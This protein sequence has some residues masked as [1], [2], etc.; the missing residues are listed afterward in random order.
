[1]QTASVES[2]QIFNISEVNFYRFSSHRAFVYRLYTI[3]TIGVGAMLF[4]WCPWLSRV[5]FYRTYMDNADWVRVTNTNRNRTEFCRLYKGTFALSPL[6]PEHPH[7]YFLYG[8]I[9]FYFS[10]KSKCFRSLGGV[11]LRDLQKSVEQ[12]EKGVGGISKPTAKRLLRH[13]RPN[14]IDCPV[15]S[16]PRLVFREVTTPFCV[17]QCFSLIV[18]ALDNYG[19]FALLILLMMSAS[20]AF[21]VHE[22]RTQQ[23]K[24]R[25][26]TFANFAVT[27]FRKRYT[28][29][30][31]PGVLPAETEVEMEQLY[32]YAESKSDR[33]AD[34]DRTPEYPPSQNMSDLNF[35]SVGLDFH[36]KKVI[37]SVDLMVGDL[38]LVSGGHI[39]PADILIVQGKCLV[40]ESILTG[41]TI[42]VA[43]VRVQPGHPVTSNNVLYSGTSCLTAKQCMGVVVKVGMYTKKGE[44]VRNL[45]FAETTHFQF[46]RDAYIFLAGIFILTTAVFVWFIFEIALGIYAQYYHGEVLIIKGLEMFTTAIP[47]ALPLCLSIGLG[48]ASQRLTKR[49]V[50]NKILEKINEAGRIRLMCFDKTGT[51]TESSLN[52]VALMPVEQFSSPAA[53]G[54]FDANSSELKI[55]TPFKDLRS[56]EKSG[57]ITARRKEMLYQVA[58]CCHSLCLLNDEVVGDQMELQFFQQT[59]LWLV[60]GDNVDYIVDRSPLE[61]LP[62]GKTHRSVTSVPPNAQGSRTI[63]KITRRFDFTSERRRMSVVA[64]DEQNGGVSVLVKGAPEVIAKLCNQTT[65]PGNFWEVLAEYTNQGLRILAAAYRRLTFEEERGTR[66]EDFETDLTFLAFLV[67]ENP[68]KRETMGVIRMLEACRVK[69]VMITGDNLMTAVSVGIKA[70]ILDPTHHIFMAQVEG[71]RLVWTRVNG[72]RKSDEDADSQMSVLDRID[73]AGFK[74]FG[75]TFPETI[76]EIVRTAAAGQ[77]SVAMT[78]DAF[79]AFFHQKDPPTPDW[80]V[81]ALLPV[82]TVFGRTSPGQKASIVALFQGYYKTSF[83]QTWLVGFCGDGANDCEALKQ[84]DVGLSISETEASIAAPFNTSIQNISPLIPLMIEGKASLETALQNFRFIIFYSIVQFFGLIACYS[85]AVE[86]S[87]PSYYFMDLFTFLP[88]SIFLT[89]GR[90]NPRL[91]R[92]FPKTS[93]LDFETLA[94]FG[95]HFLLAFLAVFLFRWT[96]KFYPELLRYDQMTD[97][98][99]I[100]ADEQFFTEPIAYLYYACVSYCVNAIIFS[101]S[102]PFK[103][104]W[105]NN[106]YLVFWVAFC[107]AVTHAVILKDDPDDGVWGP[108]RGFLRISKTDTA[109]TYLF[110]V[111]GFT[112]SFVGFV[113]EKVF[114]KKLMALRKT[115]KKRSKLRV[116]DRIIIPMN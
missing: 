82:C 40:D 34:L 115:L 111:W 85:R 47:P 59:R 102:F 46:K 31:V 67:F 104:P 10:P 41:E 88:L 43:K 78:G 51:L 17:F 93:L 84:A 9:L 44:T 39:I 110:V 24:I 19:A 53:E 100:F 107:L 58:A 75:T 108:I 3:A 56:M 87:N 37:S 16:V 50:Y 105:W 116:G 27:A 23:K 94:G 28:G 12:F 96:T 92:K 4:R 26:M 101:R 106:F 6:R 36:E 89:Y 73:A 49:R 54:N 86:W 29:P 14:V 18:W 35:T 32:P 38:V 62:V 11:F 65:I 60:D 112:F 52:L 97:D 13:F 91:N 114:L 15:E 103:E 8:E 22:I 61:P 109:Y 21:T 76:K 68:V 7:I 81:K 20:I 55:D 63:F 57:L 113:Y 2:G 64:V 95:G 42:P 5:L 79:E 70:R 83:S 74:G 77:C 99:V 45:L 66:A 72:T 30:M 69:S 25:A 33:H 90:P 1:M 98:G 48:F 80:I 71:D